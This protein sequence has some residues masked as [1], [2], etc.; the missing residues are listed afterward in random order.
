MEKQEFLEQLGGIV[1]RE[2]LISHPE[3]LLVYEYDGSIDRAMPEA[4]VLPSSTE[5][6]SRVFALAYRVGVL[7]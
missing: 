6:V 5:Q 7:R 2:N 1:G 3:D 4:V